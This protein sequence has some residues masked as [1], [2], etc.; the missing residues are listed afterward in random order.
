MRI[1]N[2]KE[3]LMMPKGTVYSKYSPH[4]FEGLMTK[5]DNCNEIDF[6]YINLIGN[7]ECPGSDDYAD[8]SRAAEGGARFNLDFDIESRDGMFDRGQLFAVYENDD[9][10][11]LIATLYHGINSQQLF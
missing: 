10:R 8:K 1:I 9:L 5:A 2:L 6:F 4:M 3:F 7:L 11:G